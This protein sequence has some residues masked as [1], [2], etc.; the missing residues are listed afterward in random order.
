MAGEA[1]IMTCLLIDSE[2]K[3]WIYKTK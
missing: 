3:G 2:E 1:Q